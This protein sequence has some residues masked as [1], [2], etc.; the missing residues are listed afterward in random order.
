MNQT[1]NF[2]GIIY[3][4]FSSGPA[5]KVVY[6]I[7]EEGRKNIFIAKGVKKQ[8]S[9]K[10]YAIDLGNYLDIKIV[11]GYA[12]PILVETKALNEFTSWKK[13]YNRIILLQF[14]CEVIDKFCFEEN[15][16]AELFKVFYNTLILTTD[17]IF[18]QSAVFLLKILNSTG[19]LPQLNECVVTGEELSIS[20][21]YYS[22]D[23]IGYLSKKASNNIQEPL[24]LISDRIIKTQKYI[25]D[26]SF[27]EALR[28][29]LT[30]EEEVK[31]LLIEINWIE[32]IIEKNLKSK[33]ILLS[34]LRSPAN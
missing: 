15:K 8:N 22:Q 33:E 32:N 18:Y 29:S 3:K 14:F 26:H 25:I 5:D 27:Q 19:N 11:E 21:I 12:V 1:K 24:E 28:V 34:I 4:I 17:K 20:N 16:D 2:K 30:K 9:K 31:M 13:E 10:A 23:H 6:L 7:D